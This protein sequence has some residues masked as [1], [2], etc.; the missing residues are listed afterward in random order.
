MYELMNLISVMFLKV[1]NKFDRLK[2]LRNRFSCIPEI[3]EYESSQR[4]VLEFS[5]VEY[6]RRFKEEKLKNSKNGF[7]SK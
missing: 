7:I 5:P 6:F 1:L 4:A 2:A 3:K